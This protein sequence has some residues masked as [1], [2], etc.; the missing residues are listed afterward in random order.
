M[1]ANQ[2]LIQAQKA[3]NQAVVGLWLNILKE[4]NAFRMIIKKDTKAGKQTLVLL[5]RELKEFVK[6]GKF[7]DTLRRS[8]FCRT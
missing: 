4:G 5:F 7:S 1:V 3:V 8:D 2:A 6:K